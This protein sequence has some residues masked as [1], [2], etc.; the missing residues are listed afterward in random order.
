ML[1]SRVLGQL[2]NL[3]RQHLVEQALCVHALQALDELL[4]DPALLAPIAAHWQEVA[5]GRNR[6]TTGHGRPTIPM[7]TYVRL[8]VSS[9]AP[10]RA[11]RLWSRSST[12][13]ATLQEGQEAA[14]ATAETLAPPSGRLSL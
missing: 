2:A 9:S 10:A 12:A 4:A 14:W 1:A 7:S 5:K 6:S 13:K 11:T 3:P 8:M